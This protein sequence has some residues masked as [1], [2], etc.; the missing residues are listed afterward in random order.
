[1]SPFFLTD[2]AP[3]TVIVGAVIVGVA[4]VLRRM[5]VNISL[6]VVMVVVV[7]GGWW[8]WRCQ[9]HKQQGKNKLS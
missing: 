4:V 1:M 9:C 3:A 7:V 8:R 6:V 2:R 5:G